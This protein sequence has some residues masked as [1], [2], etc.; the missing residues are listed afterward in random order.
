M[1]R[2]GQEDYEYLKALADAGDPE[3]AD[4][5]AAALA[6]G[7]QHNETDPGKIDAARQRIALRIEE[8]TGQHPPAMSPGTGGGAPEPGPQGGHVSPTG[9]AGDGK[10]GG[11]GNSVDGSG[12]GKGGGGGCSHGG[13]HP[14]SGELGLLVFAALVALAWRRHRRA[15]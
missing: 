9:G 5:E 3:M 7:P 10:S 6:P 1:I 8:L 13:G 2:E 12:T 15:A 4:R 11:D 14:L